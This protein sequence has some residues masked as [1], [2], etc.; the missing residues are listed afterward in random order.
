M[1]VMFSVVDSVDK[2]FGYS[3]T[4]NLDSFFHFSV[5]KLLL[6]KVFAIFSKCSPCIVK[7]LV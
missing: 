5:V 4:Q 2:I 7:F 6:S 1:Q 3:K